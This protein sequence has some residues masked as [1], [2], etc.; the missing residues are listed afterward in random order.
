[1]PWLGAQLWELLSPQAPFWIA[2][3]ACAIT[4]PIA[5]R[6]FI[7]PKTHSDNIK[8]DQPIVKI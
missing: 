3:A 2:A 6:K 8:V 7:L 1:M 4:V 5:W